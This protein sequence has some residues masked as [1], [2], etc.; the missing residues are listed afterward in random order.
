VVSFP[1]V[2]HPTFCMDLSS[3]PYVL[4]APIISSI[5]SSEYR[6]LSSSLLNLPRFPFTSSLFRPAYFQTPTTRVPPSVCSTQ[7]HT[8]TK[9]QAKL[10]FCI[11]Y[12][13]Y[14][15]IAK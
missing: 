15:W 11:N 1:Q 2:S 8:H 14:F 10:Y 9:Q 4:H 12:S 5:W 3:T 6:S 13:L 7:F